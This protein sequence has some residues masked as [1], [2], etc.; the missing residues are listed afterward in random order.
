MT[1]PRFRNGEHGLGVWPKIDTDWEKDSYGR[2]KHHLLRGGYCSG[3][4]TVPLV[5]SGGSE[6]IEMHS[7]YEVGAFHIVKYAPNQ[8]V[9]FRCTKPLIDAV[10]VAIRP[11]LFSAVF[12]K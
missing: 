9:G 7:G 5:L 6:D 10:P 11:T 1:T 12:V 3:I 4:V 8:A 2:Y